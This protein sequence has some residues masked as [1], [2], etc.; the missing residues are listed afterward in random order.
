MSNERFSQSREKD[1]TYRH[2]LFRIFYVLLFAMNLRIGIEIHTV[3]EKIV[4]ETDAITTPWGILYFIENPVPL[5]T[6]HEECH[7][8]QMIE[9]GAID[10]YANYFFGGACEEEL[11]CGAIKHLACGDN[12]ISMGENFEVFLTIK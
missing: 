9:V 6:E 5:L 3:I 8:D 10:Y 4:Q 2:L 12:T 11:R 7:Y 1:I